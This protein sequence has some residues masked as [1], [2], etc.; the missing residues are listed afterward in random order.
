MLHRIDLHVHTWYSADAAHPPEEM[1]AAARRA[2][3][4]AIAFTDHDTCAVH[5]YLLREGLMRSDGRPVNDFLIIPGVEV[6][7][8]EGHLL[9]LGHTLPWMRKEP[10]ARVMQAIA[11]RGGLGIP[12]HPYDGWRA[13][14]REEVLQS[15]PLT[16][17]EVFNAAVT[18]TSYNKLAQDY[19][20]RR[21][22]VG[23]AGSDAHHCG[24][25]GTATMSLELPEL[26]VQAVVEALRTGGTGVRR[27]EKYLSRRQGLQKHFANWFRFTKTSRPPKAGP[28]G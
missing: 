9:C 16:T 20:K 19:A 27:E 3:L 4:S 28:N 8:A 13:G 11:E 23:V 14:I 25:V 7:T 18:S 26:S 10:A 1:I 21:G 17:L 6:S 5:E 12:A 24:A 2:G 15:L 22:L